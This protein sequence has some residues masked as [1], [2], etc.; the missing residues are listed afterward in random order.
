V[1]VACPR[2][3]AD[4]GG[5]VTLD[6]PDGLAVTAA[7]AKRDV[8]VDYRPGAGVR[9]SPHFYTADDELEAFF[10]AIAPGR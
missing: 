7:L 10:E 6:I 5:T 1:S 9:V 2:R 4:R 3:S 8:L